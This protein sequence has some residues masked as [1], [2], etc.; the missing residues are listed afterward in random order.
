[1]TEWAKTEA[2][3]PG[4]ST[5]FYRSGLWEVRAITKSF[6][7]RMARTKSGRGKSVSKTHY[8]VW[9]GDTQ[10]LDSVACSRFGNYLQICDHIEAFVVGR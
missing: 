8:E 1:M 2:Q 9:F 3:T 7:D 4:G 6:W 10:V 5:R